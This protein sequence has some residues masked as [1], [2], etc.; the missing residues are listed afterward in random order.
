[1]SD[2]A[3]VNIRG[4]VAF[5]NPDKEQQ[6]IRFIDS[7]Y[8]GLFTIPNG[9]N[10]VLT[11]ID[12]A[13]ETLACEYID[14]TH[15]VIGS[16]VYHICE[17]AELMECGGTVYTPKQPDPKA[18]FGTYEIYQIK[19]IGRTDYCFRSFAEAEKKLKAVDY[20][21]VYAGMLAQKMTLDDLFWKHNRDTRPFADMMHSLSVSDVIVTTR[22]GEKKAFY[23]DSIGFQEVKNFL[24]RKPK[25]KE[26]NDER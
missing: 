4:V 22:S 5:P 19:D 16:R 23:V 13:K 21:R 10:V 12:G 20:K 25:R 24:K 8:N 17:F 7:H 18:T 9:G 6:L 3:P 11:Y 2:F 14:D 15:A 26:R 1:M